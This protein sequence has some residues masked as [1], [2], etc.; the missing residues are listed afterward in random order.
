MKQ[1]TLAAVLLAVVG[2]VPLSAQSTGGMRY[3]MKM[4]LQQVDNSKPAAN[5]LAAMA[6]A[7]I[8]QGMLP[9]GGAEMEFLTDGQSVRTELRSA[10]GNMPKGAVILYLAGQTDGLVLI[11]ANK[12]YYV[13][14]VPEA[15]VLSP[16]VKMPKPEITVKPT[17][18]FETIAGHKAERILIAWRMPMPIPEGVQVRP[19]IPT[20]LTMDI[21][22]WCT[23]D[24]K[25]PTGATRLMSGITQ[26]MPGLG[27]EELMKACP[28]A[29]RSTM[30]MSILPGYAIVSNVI[31]TSDES[32]AAE[33][34]KVPVDYKQVA[35]PV[36]RTPGGQE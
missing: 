33:L 26:S 12:T 21:D 11:P 17:G 5:S 16:G 8:K 18:T 3:V 6:V 29:M 7:Q 15:P 27:V 19:G 25:I 36:G 20:E 28:F 35:A 9:E 32:P 34:F 24:V 22:D 30:R 14:K 4:E 31:S 2:A 23:T 13:L 10:M 1:R